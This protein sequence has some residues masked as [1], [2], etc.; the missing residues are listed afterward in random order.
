MYF[1]N[2]LPTHLRVICWI[3]IVDVVKAKVSVLNNIQ[4]CQLFKSQ[5]MFVL[6]WNNVNFKRNS[7]ARPAACLYKAKTISS[8][9]SSGSIKNSVLIL[10]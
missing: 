9:I 7:L 10:T 6:R 4:L 3:L 8:E 1:Y 5:L 2:D